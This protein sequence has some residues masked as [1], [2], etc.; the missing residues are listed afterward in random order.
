MWK[1]RLAVCGVRFAIRIRQLA[2]KDWRAVKGNL[3]FVH[4]LL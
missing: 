3:N 2:E 1:D 4:K